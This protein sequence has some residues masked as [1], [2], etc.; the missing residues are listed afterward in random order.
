[1]PS[2]SASAQCRLIGR[3]CREA[4]DGTILREM[5]AEVRAIVAPAKRAV[6]DSAMS[7]L[8]KA[9]GLNR[10][11]A[12]QRVTVSL[13][14]GARTAGVVMSTSAPDTRW[15][16]SGYVKHPIFAKGPRETWRW[17]SRPPQAIPAARGWWDKPL[18]AF[19]GATGRAVVK[20]ID[21]H[22]AR[23]GLL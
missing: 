20:T 3:A 5:R 2:V 23:I 11:V 7:N 14:T 22:F 1:M 18:E 10:Q 13:L 17:V 19:G 8:P 4:G 6:H 21:A 12:G 15:T 16:N 9:G